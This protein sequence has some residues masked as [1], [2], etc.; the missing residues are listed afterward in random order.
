MD[1]VAGR[2]VG[3]G[4]GSEEETTEVGGEGEA[5]AHQRVAEAGCS[6]RRVGRGLVAAAAMPQSR[7]RLC[8]FSIFFLK[9]K[10]KERVMIF[11]R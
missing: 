5:R 4:G 9:N 10:I 2:S 11:M 1:D 3:D 8:A 7:R 6:N